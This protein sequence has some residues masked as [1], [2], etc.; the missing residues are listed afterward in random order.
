MQTPNFIVP[1]ISY[2]DITSEIMTDGGVV[3]LNSGRINFKSDEEM[4]NLKVENQT[5]LSSG[6]TSFY[7]NNLNKKQQNATEEDEVGS[8]TLGVMMTKEV[9]EENKSRLIAFANNIFVTDYTITIGSQSIPAIALSNN[10]DLILNSVAFLNDNEIE[11]TIRKN[12]G[13]VTYTATQ[14]Q[15]NIIKAII[16][17]FPIIIIIVGIIVWQ[18]RRRKK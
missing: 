17:V 14:M 18:I 6:E 8:Y 11:I 10:K 7:R 5:I 12:T 1:D 3:L 4:D 15:D 16:F 2:T 9:S 13:T